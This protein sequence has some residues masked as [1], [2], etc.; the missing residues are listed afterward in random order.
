MLHI[1]M[2]LAAIL[3]IPVA[4][5]FSAA[6]GRATLYLFPVSMYVLSALPGLFSQK[7]IRSAARLIIGAAYASLLWFWLVYANSAIAHIPYSNV[8]SI[9]NWE[10]Q[11]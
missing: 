3:L 1:Q 11:L 5:V 8:F 4:L 9:E 10:L 2:A 6:A 7:E